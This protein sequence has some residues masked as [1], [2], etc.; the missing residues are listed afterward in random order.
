MKKEMA[1]KDH[2]PYCKRHCSLKAPHCRKGKAL[3]DELKK[4]HEK[5][6]DKKKKDKSNKDIP[7]DK[8]KKVKRKAVK[9]GTVQELIPSLLYIEENESLLKKAGIQN[10]KKLIRYYILNLLAEKE[11]VTLKDLKALTTLDATVL[12]KAL[13]KLEEKEKIRIQQSEHQGRII[14]LTEKGKKKAGFYC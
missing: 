9:K 8:C 11:E 10:R 1:E 14:T 12:K 2:C 13:K 6:K 4:G 7:G 5:K 3:A